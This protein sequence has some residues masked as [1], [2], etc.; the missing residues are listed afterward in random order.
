[1]NQSV[2]GVRERILSEA[3][4]L[5]AQ[6]GVA[7]TSI[8][9]IAEA[10]GITRP[11]LVYHFGSKAGLRSAVLRSV[12]D[13]WRAE[14]PRLLAD[15]A[16]RGGPRLDALLGALFAF[17]RN[18]PELAR[19]IVR[20]MLDQPEELGAMLRAELLPWT[21]LLSD[22][23]RFGQE[24]GTLRQ[25]ADPEAFTTLIIGAAL[26]VVALGK[27]AG[28]LVEPAPTT[29]AQQAEL[30]RVARVALLLPRAP[31]PQEG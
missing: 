18:D 1:M 29:E 15:A 25:D 17:F 5:F 13:H 24:G 4:R 31:T 8:Q 2:D 9:K 10:A 12:V 26:S 30:L 7:G 23:I 28:S 11:T 14:L 21:R 16:T 6:N 22:A 20:E 27:H 19:L 3:T